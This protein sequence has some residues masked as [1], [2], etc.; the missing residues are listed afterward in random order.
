MV[1]QHR[2]SLPAAFDEVING[3]GR[4]V[5]DLGGHDGD[6][7]GLDLVVEYDDRQTIGSEANQVGTA[8]VSG[9]HDDPVNAVPE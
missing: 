4:A 3:E 2:H 6:A 9:K 8:V 5:L 7:G 1:D